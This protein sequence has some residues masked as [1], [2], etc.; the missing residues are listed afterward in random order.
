MKAVDE[1]ISLLEDAKILVNKAYDVG[2]ENGIEFEKDPGDV[3]CEIDEVIGAIV[4]E[5]A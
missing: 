5:G 4:K 2:I 3:S 1:I